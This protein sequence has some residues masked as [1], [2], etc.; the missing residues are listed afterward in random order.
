VA[1]NV[2]FVCQEI[3]VFRRAEKQRKPV[4][5][6]SPGSHSS[7][8]PDGHLPNSTASSP[9]PPH[10]TNQRVEDVPP[11]TENASTDQEPGK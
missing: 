4:A 8:Q 7:S 1:N 2:V 10:E 11:T 9:Q 3:T 5:T 6:A